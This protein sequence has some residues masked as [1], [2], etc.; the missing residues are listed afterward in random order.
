MPVISRMSILVVLLTG[1]PTFVMAA[2]TFSLED[3]GASDATV[4]RVVTVSGEGEFLFQ[5]AEA[6]GE[7]TR[8][9][10]TVEASYQ[11]L[12]RRLPG[13]GPNAAAFRALRDYADATSRITVGGQTVERA[14]R[15]DRQEIVA[16]LTRAGLDVYSRN[17]PL[18]ATEIELLPSPGD[19]LM[20]AALLPKGPVRVGQNWSPDDWTAAMLAGVEVAFEK[21]ISCQL[22]SVDES[23]A[24][25]TFTSEVEGA[26][27]GTTITTKIS[28]EFG[29]DLKEGRIVS[30]TITH[31]E[32]RG[33]GPLS[34]G[35]NITLTATLVSQPVS[36]EYAISDDAVGKIGAAPPTADELAI[37]YS[38]PWGV[39]LICD[40]AWQLF[41]RSEGRVILRLLDQGGVLAQCN[42]IRAEKVAP[43]ARTD[44]RLFQ[45]GIRDSLGEALSEIVSAEDLVVGDDKRIYRVTAVGGSESLPRQWVYYLV[46]APDGRQVSF[47]FTIEP[48]NIEQLSGRDAELVKAVRFVEIEKTKTPTPV[49]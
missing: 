19:H 32:E 8:H 7:P 2:E 49:E 11:Y 40:R 5:A 39:S 10:V 28:G 35:M 29:F 33:V 24:R 31:E 27:K 1:L 44:E 4:A 14:L 18:T 25:V 9:P 47:V 6:E 41:H 16:W 20:L 48:K 46:T 34:P 30:A 13:V 23:I 26:A 37:E 12:E 42:M 22:A 43:G 45:Q 21:K 15:E 3:G 38:F 36:Q 17:G